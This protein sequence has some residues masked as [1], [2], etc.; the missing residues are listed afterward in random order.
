MLTENQNN[1]LRNFNKDSKFITKFS[2]K[3]KFQKRKIKKL[4]I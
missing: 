3:L 2:A 1:K 4:N